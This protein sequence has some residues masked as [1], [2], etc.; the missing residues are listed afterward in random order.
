MIEIGI[1]VF[2]TDGSFEDFDPVDKEEYGFEGDIFFIH[3]CKKWKWSASLI[4]AV[5]EYQITEEKVNG[6]YVRIFQDKDALRYPAD[7]LGENNE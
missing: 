7:K 5:I 1:R 6:I 4:K 2:F 3:V